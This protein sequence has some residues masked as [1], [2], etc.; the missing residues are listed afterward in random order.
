MTLGEAISKTT[1][2]GNKEIEIFNSDYELLIKMSYENF[3]RFTSIK[4]YNTELIEYKVNEYTIT[5]II[6]I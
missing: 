5:V 4:L 2:I 1:N 3:N 6:V